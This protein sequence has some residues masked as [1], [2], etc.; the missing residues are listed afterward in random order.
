[1]R[2]FSIQKVI[3][4]S[5]NDPDSFSWSVRHGIFAHSKVKAICLAICWSLLAIAA[6]NML[7]LIVLLAALKSSF[8]Y[9]NGFLR[10]LISEFLGQTILG[11]YKCIKKWYTWWHKHPAADFL[12]R[13]WHLEL[14]DWKILQTGTLNKHNF[15]SYWQEVTVIH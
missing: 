7:K 4:R 8:L 14:P 10:T 1:M 15:N 3:I 5:S 2:F 13:Y 11:Q 12:F 6:C 9:S